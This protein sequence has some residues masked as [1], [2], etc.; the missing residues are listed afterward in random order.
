L[1]QA[2]RYLRARHPFTLDAIVVLPDHLHP[3]WTLP[4]GDADY[5]IRWRLIRAFFSR[6]IEAGE[7]ISASRERKR[8]RGIWQGRYWEQLYETTAIL[9]GAAITFTSTRS[10]MAMD[11]TSANGPIPHSTGL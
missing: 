4:P 6:G 10:N 2:F 3:I 11:G 1:P 7:R 5:A 8:E 9:S